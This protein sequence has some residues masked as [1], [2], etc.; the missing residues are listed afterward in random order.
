MIDVVPK[1]NEDPNPSMAGIFDLFLFANTTRGQLWSIEASYNTTIMN[2]V[3]CRMIMLQIPAVTTL[4]AWDCTAPIPR[5]IAHY[6]EG[7]YTDRD[8][9]LLLTSLM[10]QIGG[11]PQI[12]SVRAG[13]EDEHMVQESHGV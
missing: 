2:D 11:L 1:D 6:E 7:Q 3:T 4:A 9:G 12:V 8:G 13:W 5:H 10:M